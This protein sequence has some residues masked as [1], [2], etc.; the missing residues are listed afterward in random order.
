MRVDKLKSWIELD[1]SPE[2][3]AFSGTATYNTEFTLD[4]LSAG[5]R[6]ELDLGHVEVIASIRVNGESAGSTWSSPFR[7]DITRRVKPGV[8]R[9][10]V[11]VTST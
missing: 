5:P 3:Q 8:N 7:L 1:L 10:S 4:P 11:D 2:A 6:V 9:L